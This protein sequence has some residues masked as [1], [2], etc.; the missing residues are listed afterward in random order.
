MRSLRR[1]PGPGR[2]SRST[3]S[4]PGWTCRA[5]W[6]AAPASSASRSRCDSDAHGVGPAEPTSRTPSV[7]PGARGLRRLRCSTR[8]PLAGV[9]AFVGTKRS[10]RPYMKEPPTP[11]SEDERLKAL[12]EYN[13]LDAPNEEVFDAFARVAAKS[14]G[15]PVAVIAL[16]GRDQLTFKAHYG[17]KDVEPT[18]FAGSFTL[19]RDREHRDHGGSGRAA[20]PAVRQEPARHRKPKRH[21]D[22]E[23]RVLCR[24]AADHAGRRRDRHDRRRRQDSR[25]R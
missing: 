17:L 4:R 6:P 10:T 9:L 12:A 15:T 3:D 14:C 18:P 8:G 5:P 22:A 7:R 1:P 16:A 25:T 23:P 21:R 20:R 11:S 2:R 13:L 24:G 19:V